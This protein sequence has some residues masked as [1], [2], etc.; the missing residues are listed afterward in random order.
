MKITEGKKVTVHYVGRLSDNTEFDNSYNR[1]APITF[2]V[3]SD[4]LMK[5][6]ESAVLN[7]EVNDKFEVTIPKAE[8]YGEYIS[9][10]VQNVAISQLGLPEDGLFV[11]AQLQAAT[12]DGKEFLCHIKTINE[13]STVD[14]DLNHP[15]AGKDLNFE[16]E[17]LEVV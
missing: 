17:I 16:I 1:E 4:A 5:G 14:I 10:N 7:R 13:D 2:T 15:L 3:G 9:E 12:P 8:A 11:G 6:F